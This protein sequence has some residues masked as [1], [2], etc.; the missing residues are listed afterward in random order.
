INDKTRCKSLSA[1]D[2]GETEERIKQHE[3]ERSA[4]EVQRDGSE[5][6]ERMPQG[7]GSQLPVEQAAASE[8]HQEEEPP[9][10]PPEPSPEEKLLTEIRD[11]L[12]AQN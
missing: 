6:Q 8:Q 12:K 2:L 10:A 9:P 1:Q 4:L 7:A 5:V 11:L 3:A